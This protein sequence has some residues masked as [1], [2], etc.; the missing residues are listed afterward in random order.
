MLD[1][2][3]VRGKRPPIVTEPPLPLMVVQ[4]QLAVIVVGPAD[5]KVRDCV[6]HTKTVPACCV[7]LA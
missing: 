6:A 7:P 2:G 5:G 1:V 3:E 4:S